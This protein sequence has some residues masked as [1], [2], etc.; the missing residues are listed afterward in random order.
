LAC[1]NARQGERTN[2]L[3]REY[4]GKSR[5]CGAKDTLEV[6]D[7]KSLI[8]IGTERTSKLERS[9]RAR[10]P[11]GGATQLDEKAIN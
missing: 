7:P 8:R 4:S 10:N 5:E 1:T 3:W 6:K 2:P 11:P 9:A